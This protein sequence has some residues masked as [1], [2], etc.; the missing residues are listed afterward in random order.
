MARG[1]CHSDVL[2]KEGLWPGIQYPRLPG[3]EVAGLVDEVGEGVTAW[4]KGK[5]VRVGWHGGEGNTCPAAILRTAGTKIPGISYDGGYQ[6]YMIAPVE[7][8]TPRR[9]TFVP[10]AKPSFLLPC[11]S[12]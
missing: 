10:C 7:V 4:K 3:Q 12:R 11:F 8:R 1:I 5:R 6:E 9:V 2:T